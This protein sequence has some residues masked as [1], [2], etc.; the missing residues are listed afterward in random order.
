[1]DR[2]TGLLMAVKEVELFHG[3]IPNQK[4][5]KAVLGALER[6][7]ELLKDL[8]HKNIVQY[9]CASSC[10]IVVLCLPS[11]LVRFVAGRQLFQHSF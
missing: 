5:K 7:I 6:E 1:M 11:T 8:K 10:L 3:S 9:F 2:A 4:R